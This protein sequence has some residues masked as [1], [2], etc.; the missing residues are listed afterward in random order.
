MVGALPSEGTAVAAEKLSSVR[1]ITANLEN[2][3]GSSFDGTKDVYVGVIG[4]LP[5][6]HGGTGGTTAADARKKLG[7]PSTDTASTSAN[8]LMSSADKNKL[9]G[10]EEG[11]NNTVVDNELSSFSTNPVQNKVVNEAI[12]EIN[13]KLNGIEDGANKTIVDEALSST[14]TNPVQNKAVNSI[15]TDLTGQVTGVKDSCSSMWTAS[16]AYVAGQYAIY[17]NYIYRCIK[18]ASAGTIPTNTTYWAK[19]DLASEITS[20]NSKLMYTY[21]ILWDYANVSFGSG[22]IN[23]SSEGCTIFLV[24]ANTERV[25]FQIHGE[26]TSTDRPFYL[27]YGICGKDAKAPTVLTQGLGRGEFLETKNSESREISFTFGR[28]V[29]MFYVGGNNYLIEN[30]MCIKARS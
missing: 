11:A 2:E 24:P 1:K 27:Q 3:G 23:A 5:V 20:L 15:I 17:N 30:V 14:S 6:T 22:Q 18:N 12:V 25:V 21:P 4:T 26:K 13:E 8:G 16:Q 7:V 19:T 28:K 29:G 10:V 9:N